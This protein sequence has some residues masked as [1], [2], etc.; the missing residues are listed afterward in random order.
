[1]TLKE[2][3]HWYGTDIRW[4]FAEFLNMEDEKMYEQVKC[5]ERGKSN[6]KWA[7]GI[8]KLSKYSSMNN[9]KDIQR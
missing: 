5:T 7:I 1:M 9:T 4:L 6:K 8:T 2:Y 3:I